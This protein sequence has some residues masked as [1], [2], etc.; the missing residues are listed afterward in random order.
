MSRSSIPCIQ[1]NN[2]LRRF[3]PGGRHALRPVGALLTGLALAAVGH[4]QTFAGHDDFSGGDARWAYFFRAPA[5]TTGTN[6]ILTFNGSV[7]EFTKGANSGSYLLG[8]DGDGSATVNASRL[9]ASYTTNWMAEISATN[10]HSPERGAFSSVGFE[11]AVA[12]NAYTE[13]TLEKSSDGL[14]RVRTETNSATTGTASAV[15]PTADDIRLRIAWDATAKVLTVSYSLDAGATYSTLRTVPITEWNVQPTG[16]FYIELMGYS[17]AAAAIPAGQMWLDNFS[18]T[19]VPAD[20][21]RLGN[22]SVRNLTA[23]GART[24]IVGFSVEGPGARPLVIRG[25]SETLGRVFSVPNVLTDVDLALYSSN[26]T[27]LRTTTSVAA[28]SSAAFQRVGA[29]ALD[30]GTTDAGAVVQLTA[31]TYTLHAIPAATA[32]RREGNALIEVYED[33]RLGTRLTN[34]SA[35][36][37]LG[38]EPLIVGFYA[39]GPQRTRVLVRAAGP[40]LAAFGITG[41]VTDPRISVVRMSD[42]VTV[43]QNDDWG[44]AAA[45]VSAAAGATGAFAL[46]AG[47]KDAAL[48]LDLEPGNYTVRLQNATTTSGIVL[49][50][51]YQ[52]NP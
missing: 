47:S 2:R 28:G 19:T 41:F 13:I 40:A 3:F 34:V 44:S 29:F 52:V 22:L 7:L 39:A 15:V 24:L 33:G 50:E 18:V 10:R 38:T 46:P 8:W 9:P 51:V 14:T 43:A 45:E 49:A 11:V 20:Y 36:T 21:A 6:G 31:G 1:N 16:G 35:R 30:A 25:I 48:V 23:E 32:T 37:E 12:P 5:L 27:L 17:V 42:G 26:N 4:A